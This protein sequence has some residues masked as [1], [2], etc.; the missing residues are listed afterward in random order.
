[1]AIGRFPEVRMAIAEVMIAL[2]AFG[3]AKPEH[4]F[5]ASKDIKI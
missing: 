2:C 3:I 4:S 5:S 1:M